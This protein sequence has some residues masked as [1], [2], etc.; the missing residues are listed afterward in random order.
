MRAAKLRGEEERGSVEDE[1]DD[2]DDVSPNISS[3]ENVDDVVDVLS[4]LLLS[5]FD[6][7]EFVEKD[8]AIHN[9]NKTTKRMRREAQRHRGGGKKSTTKTYNY[10]L[11]G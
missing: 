5:S 9:I 3:N 11:P 7:N 4:A 2:D 6:L 8:E 1:V 10:N